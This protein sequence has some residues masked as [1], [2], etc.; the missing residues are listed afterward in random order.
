MSLPASK[1]I[2]YLLVLGL[3]LIVFVAPVWAQD[4]RRELAERLDKLERLVDSQGMAELFVRLQGLQDQMQRLQGAIELQGHTLQQFQE[5]QHATLEDFDRRL[6]MLEEGTALSGSPLLGQDQMASV[7]T[8]PS[9]DPETLATDGEQPP[10]EGE[11]ENQTAEAGTVAQADSNDP[12]AEPP[13]AQQAAYEQAFNLLKEGNYSEAGQ[14][15]SAF[16]D[17]YPEAGNAGNA[18]YWLAETYYVTRQFPQAIAAFQTVLDRYPGSL[19]R[20]DAVLKIGFIHYEMQEWDEARNVLNEVVAQYPN[21]TSAELA[22][23]RLQ[24]MSEEEN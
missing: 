16:I 8:D 20:S 19:K 9:V 18:Q 17:Q 7:Q 14:A 5:S 15:F 24:R 10:A 11:S 23:T 4:S 3:A 6:Q 13:T 12:G 22:E 1:P 21:T 2:G